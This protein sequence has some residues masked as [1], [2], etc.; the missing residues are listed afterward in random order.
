VQDF[1]PHIYLKPAAT[2]DSAEAAKPKRIFA[3]DIRY[4]YG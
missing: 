1:S 3:T 4:Y 2:E